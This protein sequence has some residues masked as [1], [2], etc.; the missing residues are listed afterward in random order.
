MSDSDLITRFMIEIRCKNNNLTKSF[1]EGSTLLDVFNGFPDLDF[2]YPPVSARVNHSSQGLKFR[3]YQSRDV[4]FLDVRTSGGMR[5]YVRS[6][7]FVL[8]KAS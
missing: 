6:L 2:E 3:V 7:C 5:A 1:P 4:E 8:Y